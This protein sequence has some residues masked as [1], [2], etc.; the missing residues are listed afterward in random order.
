M[1]ILKYKFKFFNRYQYFIQFTIFCY[2]FKDK[3][4]AWA[5]I[6]TNYVASFKQCIESFNEF[7]SVSIHAV[8][9]LFG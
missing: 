2:L 9:F 7:I 6:K 5:T 8:F 4:R 3:V 1:I